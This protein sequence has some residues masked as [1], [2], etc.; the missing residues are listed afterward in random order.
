MN[1]VLAAILAIGAIVNASL[2][3]IFV[4]I[5]ATQ[6]HNLPALYGV[7][8]ATGVTY[9]SYAAQLMFSV[10]SIGRLLVFASVGLGIIAGALLLVGV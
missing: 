6:T 8:I 2:Y 3:F 10:S 5:T 1:P 7:I 9:L 4:F